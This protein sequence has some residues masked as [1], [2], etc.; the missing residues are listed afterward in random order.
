M[1]LVKG[2]KNIFSPSLT[3]LLIALSLIIIVILVYIKNKTIDLFD[4]NSD[5]LQLIINKYQDKQLQRNNFA[6]TLAT[7]EQTIKNLQT[8]VSNVLSVK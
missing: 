7:Q 8:Q 1:N 2:F 6:I 5:Y 4:E 3:N